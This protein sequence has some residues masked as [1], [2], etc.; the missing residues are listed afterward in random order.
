MKAIVYEKY[1]PVDSLQLMEVDKPTPKDNEVLIKVQA[2]SINKA[3]FSMITGKPFIV[4]FFSGLFKP[5]NKIPGLDMAG[6]VEEVGKNVSKFKIGDDVLGD[7]YDSGMGGFSEYTC[8]DEKLLV[9][10]PSNATFEEAATIP[11]AGVTAFQALVNKGQIKSGQS[12]SV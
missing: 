9:I 11:V 1:G 2:T 3:D 10:K 4:R 8:A 12:F 5:K 6:T 7:I